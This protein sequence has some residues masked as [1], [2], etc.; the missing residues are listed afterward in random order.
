VAVALL[1]LPA[2]SVA[3]EAVIAVEI[4]GFIAEVSR[5]ALDDE[6]AVDIELLDDMLLKA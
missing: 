4:V 3:I 1:I 2:V 5:L 6:F